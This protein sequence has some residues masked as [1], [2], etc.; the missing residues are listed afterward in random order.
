VSQAVGSELTLKSYSERKPF[1][2]EVQKLFC[3]Q[4]CNRGFLQMKLLR[5]NSRLGSLIM[6]W[7]TLILELQTLDLILFLFLFLFFVI[8]YFIFAFAFI[9]F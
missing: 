6:A 8:F 1:G 3:K 2:L 9:L 4:N 5:S 7:F